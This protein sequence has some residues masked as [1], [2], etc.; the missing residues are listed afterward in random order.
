MKRARVLIVGA[1]P[2]GSVTAIALRERGVDGVVLV[3]ASD[4]GTRRIGES[5]L[6]LARGVLTE[7]GLLK[8]FERQGHAC[9]RGSCS[10][11]GDASLAYKDYIRTPY[12]FGWHLDRT[13]FDAWLTEEAAARGAQVLRSTR[14]ISIVR[15]PGGGFVAGLRCG[16]DEWTVLAERVVDATGPRAFVAG[17]LGAERRVLDRFLCIY[18]F[19]EILDHRRSD[20][21]LLEAGAHGWWYAADL[22]GDE[23]VVALACER[24]TVRKL[25]LRDP[26]AWA[27]QVAGTDHVSSRVRGSALHGPLLVRPALS[28]LVSPVAGSG[29]LAVGDAAAAFDPLCSHGI[30]KALADGLNA[31]AAVADS[32]AGTADALTV[33]E[34]QIAAR[35]SEYCSARD[36]LYQLERRWPDALFWRRRRQRALRAA[37]ATMGVV[38][39]KT[40]LTHVACAEGRK[41]IEG[42]EFGAG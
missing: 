13:R 29:W 31:G 18:G 41:D 21:T 34:A 23:Q 33:Y 1:G 30:T 38:V 16:S 37:E 39:R 15:N 11:W 5:L 27:A 22:S 7:L 26:K 12:G 42:A 20:R 8:S 3:E 19:H 10:A 9:C 32:L 14:C 28:M 25:G 36:T 4:Y 40:H 35:W 2:A 24:E 6:P 17:E